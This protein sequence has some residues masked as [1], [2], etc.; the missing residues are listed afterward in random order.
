MEFIFSTGAAGENLA[1]AGIN[2]EIIPSRLEY[3]YILSDPDSDYNSESKS[4]ENI[5]AD[6]SDT[7]I[8]IEHRP[9]PAYSGLIN[10]AER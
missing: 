7:K 6:I 2:F 3:L 8:T 5:K 4:I 1:A 9:A 10:H